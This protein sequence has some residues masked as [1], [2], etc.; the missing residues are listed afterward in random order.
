MVCRQI[1]RQGLME[2]TYPL[3]SPG[4]HLLEAEDSSLERKVYR[5]LTFISLLPS[6]RDQIR[7]GETSRG[8]DEVSTAWITVETGH[9]KHV[10]SNSVSPDQTASVF[11]NKWSVP[12][13]QWASSLFMN[14]HDLHQLD[15]WHLKS[16]VWDGVMPSDGSTPSSCL[17]QCSLVRTAVG[18]ATIT[19]S[20]PDSTASSL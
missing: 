1:S 5:R 10:L 13:S 18:N 16:W 19:Q 12:S 20:H 6:N 3:T 2:H 15:T 4:P 17:D 14:Q 11:M 7:E 8:R 9:C